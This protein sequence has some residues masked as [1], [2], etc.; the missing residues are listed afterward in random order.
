MRICHL[1]KYYAP[2]RGGIETHVQAIAR[3]QH[4]SGVDVT[5]V[6]INHQDKT[7]K[8]VWN[9]RLASTPRVSTV[10]RGVKVERFP[11]FATLARFDF[12]RGLTKYISDTSSDFD[13][14][15][16]H[17]PNPT[18]CCA[19]ALAKP[20]IPLVVT[21]HSDIVKQ[22]FIRK[23]FR[24]VENMVFSRASRFIASTAAYADSSQVLKP[25]KDRVT[26]IPFGLDLEP[27]TNPRPQAVQFQ[28]QLLDKAQGQPIWLCVGRLVY[29]KGFENA[30]RALPRCRGRLML[31][32]TGPLRMSFKA[33]A[34]KLD[35]AERID[36]HDHLSDDELIGAY[37]AATAFWF[38]SVARSEAFGLVQV[39]AMASGCPVINTRIDGSGVPSVSLD[40][41][42]GLTVDV[43]NPIALAEAANKIDANPVLRAHLSAGAKDRAA[44]EFSL[45]RMVEQTQDLYRSV[46]RLPTP[47][48]D[49]LSLELRN[50]C[51]SSKN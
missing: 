11:K 29:Y 45:K 43:A 18:L 4:E 17:V 39:E 23:P 32:G 50:S 38:P 34:A 1:A 44:S 26:T 51:A 46:L 19:L 14:F 10:D 21:Y 25:L 15:H 8:D 3:A 37:H 9:D 42:S 31:V 24:V 6:C 49:T 30:I 48:S 16:L 5:V 33:L 35:V 7:G 2:F 28:K 13:L 22:R 36:W 41:V 40:G 20:K 12:C 27:Y 47:C